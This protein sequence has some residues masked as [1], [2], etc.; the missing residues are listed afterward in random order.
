MAEA[1]ELVSDAARHATIHV[2][3]LWRRY[4]PLPE[5]PP[6]ALLVDIAPRLDLLISAVTGSSHA[7]RNAQ[8]PARPTLLARFFRRAREPWQQQPLPATDGQRLW[9]HAD[10]G[11]Q[12]IENGAEAY[13]VMALQQALLAQRGTAQ[14]LPPASP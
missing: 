6:T 5:G 1:E 8:L 10:S 3:R 13:R 4:R 9:R 7:I 14:A 12:D 2:Q 11:Q